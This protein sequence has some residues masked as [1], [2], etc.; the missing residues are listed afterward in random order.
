[1]HLFLAIEFVVVGLVFLLIPAHTK[2]RERNSKRMAIMYRVLGV[3]F[4]GVS[5][6]NLLRVAGIRFN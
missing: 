5:I 3:A 1:V 4:F 6:L 2:W